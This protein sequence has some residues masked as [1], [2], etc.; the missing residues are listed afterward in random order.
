MY[1]PCICVIST[2]Y[3]DLKLITLVS[4]QVFSSKELFSKHSKIKNRH[5]IVKEIFMH[6]TLCFPL[7]WLHF[8]MYREKITNYLL[9]YV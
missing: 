1:I 3:D 7:T 8:D 9:T 2:E 5:Y 4:T 6:A